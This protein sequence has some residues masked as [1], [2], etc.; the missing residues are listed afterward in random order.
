MEPKI[1]IV[2][3]L[4]ILIV[5]L[6]C[7]I[8]NKKEFFDDNEDVVEDDGSDNVDNFS[9]QQLIN[10]FDSLESAEKR[11]RR[12]EEDANI[13]QERDL[14]KE[15][16]NKFNEL[17][18]LDKKILELKDILKDITIEK[19]RRDGIN[20][21]CQK[22]NQVKLN[23]NYDILNKLHKDG[24]VTDNK[25]NLDLNVSESLTNSLKNLKYSTEPAI[26]DPTSK[27]IVNNNKD[28]IN[29]KDIKGCYNCD[30][31]KLKKILP[32]LQRDFP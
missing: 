20:N 28:Y 4:T 16:E 7:V 26:S 29:T 6:L 8:Y 23:Q 14:I 31:A 17:D 12:I 1:I 24:L 10:M 3:I 18:E 22:N 11:C 13:Q 25:V 5:I 2:S 21:K 15:N 9:S 32:Y 19:G 27:C 30:E